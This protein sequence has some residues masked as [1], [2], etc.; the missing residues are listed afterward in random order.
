MN[1]CH[2][3]KSFACA[4]ALAVLLV[5]PL[6]VQAQ[7][8]KPGA[9]VTI[10]MARATW[11]T[12]WFPAEIYKQLL[13][14][15]GYSVPRYI[16]LGNA[17]FYRA[18]GRGDV[19]FWVNGWFPLHNA[20]KDLFQPGAK[21]IGYVAKDGSLQGYLVDKATVEKYN[22]K[23]LADI[24]RPEVRQ[25]LD[26]NGDG[27]ADLVACPPDWG[28]HKVISYHMKAYGLK[29]Y[30]NTLT[31]SYTAAMAQAIRRHKHGKPIFFYT[32]TPNWTVGVL[33][34]GKDVMWITVKDTKLPPPQDDLEDD[35]VLTHLTGCVTDPCNL[36]WPVND[37]RPVANKQ[38]LDNNP[39]AAALIKAVRI[40]L[41]DIFAENAKLY[42][43]D[44]D[45][46]DIERQARNWID[47]H[48]ARVQ[49][50]LQ[51]ARAAAS[52][53]AQQQ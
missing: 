2:H 49:Q 22:I 42:A 21:I 30:V 7:N 27:K 10:R 20:Y 50:W 19:D 40:P 38:F 35:T 37:I 15:L 44:N 32:W 9:G 12:G 43:G 46:E 33:E 3:A 26:A 45:Q 39:A 8:N 51:T 28:C 41:E 53:Q 23:T 14:K 31:T 47:N 25:A 36:G 34:P 13:E 1:C 4:A 17:D 11:S 16:T 24:K 5:A 18:V 52:S 48:H 6:S 29:P